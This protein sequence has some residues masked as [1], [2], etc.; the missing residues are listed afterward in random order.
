MAT[1]NNGFHS[2]SAVFR[3]INFYN[4][5]NR[6]LSIWRYPKYA[7]GLFESS[8]VKYSIIPGLHGCTSV[9]ISTFGFLALPVFNAVSLGSLGQHLLDCDQVKE[10]Y[11]A[12]SQCRCNNNQSI[13]HLLLSY[14]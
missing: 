13:T 1:K 6:E 4:M 11:M 7:L 2:I 3:I 14:I 12:S 9:T 10:S 8:R 5:Q